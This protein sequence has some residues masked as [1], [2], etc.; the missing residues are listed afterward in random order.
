VHLLQIW[1]LPAKTGT[2]PSYEQRTFPT[3]DKHGRLKLVGAPDGRDGAV[4]IHQDVALYA[5]VLD[6][7]AR[8]QHTLAPGR[9][10]W[11]QVARGTIAV[12]GRTLAAGDGVAVSDESR[13]DLAGI[14]ESELLLFDLA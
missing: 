13:L 6:P 10:A 9:H 4:T 7:G 14:D 11:V 12:N 8:V 5:S 3:A 2:P 1:L